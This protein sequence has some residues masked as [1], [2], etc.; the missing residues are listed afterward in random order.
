MDQNMIEKKIVSVEE[1]IS[2]DQA[3]I[4]RT[5]ATIKRSQE[6]KKFLEGRIRANSQALSDLNNRKA[7]LAIEGSIGKVDEAKLSLLVAFLKEHEDDIR[8]EEDEGAEV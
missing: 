6:R 3:E 1:Q 4:E 7:M 8:K 5:A 2:R